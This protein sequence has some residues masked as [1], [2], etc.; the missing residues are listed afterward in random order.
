MPFDKKNLSL[1]GSSKVRITVEEVSLAAR[2]TNRFAIS[3]CKRC[4]DRS[5]SERP[6]QS[7]SPEEY[8]AAS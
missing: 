3:T 8:F 7:A 5:E 2:E 6:L 4:L 1:N